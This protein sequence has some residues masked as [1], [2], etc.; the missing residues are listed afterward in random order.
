MLTKQIM[1]NALLN[2]D[3][4]FEGIFFVAVKTTG[5]FCRPTCSAKKPKRENVEF[6]STCREA[7]VS[8]YRPC[9]VCTPLEKPGETPQYIKKLINEICLN[10]SLKLKDY[11]L[12]SRNLE[13]NKIRR[14]FKKNW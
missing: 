9:K 12:R 1:Y 14:W 8:G 11:D 6:F 4:S 13:P 5:I 10:P 3:S 2:K 7:I